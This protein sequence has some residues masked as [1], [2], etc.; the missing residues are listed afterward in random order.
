MDEI[1]IFE[2]PNFGKIRIL[3]D[4]ANNLLFNAKDVCAALG[5]T[6]NRKAIIDHINEDDVTKRDTIDDLGRIQQMAYITESGLYCLI[7]GSKLENAKDFKHWVTSEVLPSIRKT[8]KYSVKSEAAKD[9]PK[10]TPLEKVECKIKAADWAVKNLHPDD[11]TRRRM[12]RDI[13]ETAGMKDIIPEY[14]DYGVGKRICTTAEALRI[15]KV[16]S[17]VEEFYK[18]LEIKHLVWQEPFT[19][20]RGKVYIKYILSPNYEEL[21]FN[22]LDSP[23]RTN[24]RWYVNEFKSVLHLAYNTEP[25]P[26]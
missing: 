5:Y 17:T 4:G 20:K 14:E 6:N 24:I 22:I 23:Q 7:F 10:Q 19:G 9:E 2:N 21:G 8:G 25:L 15:F 16:K 26:F 1:K 13:M 11:A 3:E 18:Q 12:A